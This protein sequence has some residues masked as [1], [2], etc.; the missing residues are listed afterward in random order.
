MTPICLQAHTFVALQ[1]VLTRRTAR[2]ASVAQGSAR[3]GYPAEGW[4]V[5]LEYK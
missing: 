2:Y 3:P 5:H 1:P 4:V